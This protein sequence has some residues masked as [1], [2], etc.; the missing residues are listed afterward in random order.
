MQVYYY[1]PKRRQKKI[2]EELERQAAHKQFD[3]FWDTLTHEQRKLI[4]KDLKKSVKVLQKKLNAAAMTVFQD[5][6]LGFP[7]GIVDSRD[8]A[9]KTRER[10]EKQGH[11]SR[12]VS[13]SGNLYNKSQKAWSR[14]LKKYDLTR[15]TFHQIDDKRKTQIEREFIE[16]WHKGSTPALGQ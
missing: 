14:F 16:Y 13:P 4:V 1:I 12:M 8:V 2:A 3:E 11:P 7:E 6:L 9:R 10:I 5:T 15:E